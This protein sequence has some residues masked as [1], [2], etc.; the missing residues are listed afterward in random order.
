MFIVAKL[1]VSNTVVDIT[2]AADPTI[3]SGP[4]T[5]NYRLTKADGEVTCH[6]VSFGHG[7]LPA[8]N[9]RTGAEA[10]ARLFRILDRRNAK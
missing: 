7:N 3:T 9:G 8:T 2:V 1:V 10:I 6:P 5:I 4:D